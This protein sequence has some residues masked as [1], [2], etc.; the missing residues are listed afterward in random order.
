[1]PA[2]QNNPST[3]APSDAMPDFT[4]AQIES[5]DLPEGRPLVISDADEVLVR[6]AEP[7]EAF[8]EDR[9]LF[10]NISDYRLVGNVRRRSDN[11]PVERT[12]LFGLIDDFFAERVDR[13]PIV[14]GAAEALASLAKD[15]NVVVLTNVPDAY[16][17]RRAKAFRTFG[18]D[19]PVVSN[20]GLKGAAVRALADRSRGPVAFIDD[21]DKHIAAVAEHV[22]DSYRVHFV[23]D[24]RLA[25]VCERA[26]HSHHR[27]DC[28]RQT[29]EAIGAFLGTARD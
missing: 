27:S 3:D 11:A 21:I 7:L 29:T 8:L 1:M 12:Q 4:R 24:E 22:P 17:E 9:G 28:W 15:A 23:A 5:L 14:E 13:M 10:F 25:A 2:K 16:R 18:L 19:F 26:E 20:S 6:F